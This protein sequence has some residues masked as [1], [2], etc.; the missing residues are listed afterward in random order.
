MINGVDV[1]S[2]NPNLDYAQLAKSGV[3]FAWCKC[4][5]GATVL[6]KMHDQHTTGFRAAGVRTGSYCFGHTSQDAAA[7][8]DFFLANA[9]ID[10]LKPVIDME[11]LSQ[12]RVPDNAG[13]WCLAWLERVE[14]ITGIRAIIYAST[15]YLAA[16]IKQC[17]ALSAYDVWL[18]EYHVPPSPDRLPKVTRMVAWQWS[19]SGT[20]PG[21]PTPIDRDVLIV[22]SLDDVSVT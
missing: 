16:M 15:S 4:S 6:D 11:T 3:A 8:A 18:A 19:G 13:E 5:E 12:G 7:T 20:L 14:R 17:P 9:T 21:A 10:Q 1:S 2:Y 22:D